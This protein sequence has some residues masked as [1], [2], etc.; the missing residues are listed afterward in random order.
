MRDEARRMA[1]NS[2]SSL[3]RQ[4]NSDRAKA[5]KWPDKHRGVALRCS[6]LNYPTNSDGRNAFV[7][8]ASFTDSAAGKNAVVSN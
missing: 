4:A 7:V 6:P 3:R 5:Q 8:A 2:I 1:L